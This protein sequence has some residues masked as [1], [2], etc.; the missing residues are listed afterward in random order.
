MSMTRTRSALL[1]MGINPDR[2][3]ASAPATAAL[4][5]IVDVSTANATDLATAQ[6]LANANKTKLNEI[7][8]KLRTAKIIT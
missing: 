8:A 4:P 7:L 2:L 5:A 3:K 6:A 1:G